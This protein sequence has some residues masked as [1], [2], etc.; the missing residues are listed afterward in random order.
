V[1]VQ[2]TI[3]INR[4]R[5]V[6]AALAADPDQATVWYDDI[7]TPPWRSASP[8]AVGTEINVVAH[9][10]DRTLADTYEVVEL[11]PDE[12]FVMRTT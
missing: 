4:P 7:A 9:I 1:D 5:S 2:S 8:L 12:R 6:I 3:K 11:H 10:L